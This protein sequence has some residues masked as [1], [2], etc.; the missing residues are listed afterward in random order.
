MKFHVNSILLVKSSYIFSSN[1]VK[2]EHFHICSSWIFQFSRVHAGKKDSQTIFRFLGL[3]DFDVYQ[4]IIV[5]YKV[6]GFHGIF[7]H[8]HVFY[9]TM[10]IW[11]KAF[12][13]HSA[14]RCINRTSSYVHI[15]YQ[16]S[17]S[18]SLNPIR[19]SFFQSGAYV[20]RTWRGIQSITLGSTRRTF[21]RATRLS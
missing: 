15:P 21:A 12:F 7:F 14:F 13:S 18:S 6:D 5:R 16:N 1:I 11:Q 19:E 8:F 17:L 10:F 20:W 2:N 3:T 9:M 4:Q